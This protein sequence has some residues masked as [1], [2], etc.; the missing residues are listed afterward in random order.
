MVLLGGRGERGAR[1]GD[2]ETR[3]RAARC[4]E[5][6]LPAIHA[7]NGAWPRGPAMLQHG[8]PLSLPAGA[9]QQGQA[10]PRAPAAKQ[11]AIALLKK[12]KT[13]GVL[14]HV[15]DARRVHHGLHADGGHEARGR[16]RGQGREGGDNAEHV[17]DLECS[18]RLPRS[19]RGS[20][21]AQLALPAGAQLQR[22]TRASPLLPASAPAPS[23]AISL[24]PA[25]P[26]PAP[27]RGW[28]G[29][30][31]GRVGTRLRSRIGRLSRLAGCSRVIVDRLAEPSNASELRAQR[32]AAGAGAQ[33]LTGASATPSARAR[34]RIG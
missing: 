1:G 14:L 3:A 2:T 9:G 20:F 16:S 29:G 23:G 24:D 26:S 10:S 4:A 32:P 8:Q 19:S 28:P 27:T 21:D 31:C 17:L 12:S 25:R 33:T 5:R 22:A 18:V 7:A 30:L 15:V 13:H 34:R 6:K 11:Q